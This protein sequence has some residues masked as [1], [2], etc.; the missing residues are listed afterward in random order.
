LEKCENFERGL[1]TVLRNAWTHSEA[2]QTTDMSGLMDYI[3]DVL[4]TANDFP[5]QMS[6]IFHSPA[7]PQHQEVMVFYYLSTIFS[8]LDKVAENTITGI[9]RSR[10]A[11]IN[12]AR[13]LATYHTL[14]PRSQVSKVAEALSLIAACEDFNTYFNEYVSGRD[15]AELLG[16]LKVK[17][18]AVFATDMEARRMLRPL[19]DAVDKAQRKYKKK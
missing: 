18:L 9:L 10:R 1:G 5:T 13:L 2:L 19:S 15:E 16:D 4:D 6:S 7:A 17:C 12:G 8:N 14:L 11:F 3:C